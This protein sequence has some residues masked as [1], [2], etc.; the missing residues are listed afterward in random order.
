MVFPHGGPV[1]RHPSQLYEAAL[2]GLV[3]FAVLAV[4]AL[5]T[6]MLTRP[7]LATGVFLTGYGVA[8]II[9]ELFRQ[10]DAYLGFLFAGITM[11]QL[12]SLP[13]LI[14]GLYLIWRQR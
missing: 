1:P 8:R 11:G 13:V 6:R 14:A 4:L 12:L 7:G 9:G 3:L 5:R 10:P 2:E